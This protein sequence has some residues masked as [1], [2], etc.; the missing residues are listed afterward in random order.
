[1]GDLI[2][3]QVAIDE[4]EY[5]INMINSTLDSTTLDFNARE[6]LRQRKG[7]AME[8]LNSIQMLP[9]AEKTGKWIRITQG[10]D[11]EKYMCPFCHRTVENY[12][13]DCMVSIR[14]PYCHCGARM[15]D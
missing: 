11:P 3:R 4:I 10:A 9:S 1:M 6:R 7:E 13:P 2:D 5:E 8:I 14:Y 15:V 12:G